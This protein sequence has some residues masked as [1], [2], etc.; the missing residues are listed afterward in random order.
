M[1]KAKWGRYTLEFKQQAARL[2]EL[3]L[4]RG[5]AGGEDGGNRGQGDVAGRRGLG[6]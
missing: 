2:V 3:V 6:R 5:Q 4:T 1:T